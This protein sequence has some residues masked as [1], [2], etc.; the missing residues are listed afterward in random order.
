METKFAKF[1]QDNGIDA[2]RVISA[3]RLIE[4][5]Q[6]EDRG[7]RL[8]K[9]LAKQEDSKLGDEEKAALKAKKPRTGRPVTPR[10]VAAANTGKP[11]TG[12]AKTRLLRAVNR[13]LEQKKKPAVDLRALF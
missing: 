2:R 1:L 12:P 11:V 7:L 8:Q 10:L 4:R 9:R 6:P 5:L 13:I 3:S